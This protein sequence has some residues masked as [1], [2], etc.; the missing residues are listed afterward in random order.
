MDI[1]LVRHG[2][3]VGREDGVPDGFRPLTGKGRRRF[4]KTA[5]AF[6]KLGRRKLDLILSSPLVRA[7]QTAEILAGEARHGEVGVLEELD[8]EFGVESLLEALAKRADGLKSVA[9]VG[10]EPQLSSVLAVLAGVPADSLDL[11]KGAIVHLD[12]T[13]LSRPGSAG[14]YWSLKPRSKTVEKGL[15]LAKAEGEEEE[16]G[17]PRRK[18]RRARKARSGR[19]QRRR[20]S[21]SRVSAETGAEAGS[22]APPETAANAES[23]DE[24]G[25][26]DAAAAEG[27]HGTEGSSGSPDH[28]SPPGS[29]SPV[30]PA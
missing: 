25:A 7:V 18:P 5:R 22:S 28:S 30:Q 17:A 2:I 3:A 9:L 12:G 26:A 13:D 20:A 11:K 16:A 14:A 23:G 1:Y 10:H 4:R 15:P 19:S 27:Q 29:D 6:A 24:V 8:P 21:R